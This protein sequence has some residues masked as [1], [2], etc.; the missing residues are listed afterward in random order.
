[1]GQGL[2]PKRME[3]SQRQEVRLGKTELVELKLIQ[4]IVRKKVGVPV[5]LSGLIRAAIPVYLHHLC[6]NL[7]DKDWSETYAGLEKKRIIDINE[8]NPERILAKVNQA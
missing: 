3:G 2:K 7:S 5:S 4:D 6:S 8:L 1:M